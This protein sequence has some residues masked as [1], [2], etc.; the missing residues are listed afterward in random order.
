MS[1][2]AKRLKVSPMSVMRLIREGILSA[3]Q[4]MPCAPRLILEKDLNEPSVQ[5]AVEAIRRG[6]KR[7][8]P[9]NANQK[10]LDFP[11]TS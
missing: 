5:G 8:L 6:A 10:L 7:P 9:E 4:V 1:E 11:T 3:R 2:A